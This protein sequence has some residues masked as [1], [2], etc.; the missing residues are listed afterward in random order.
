MKLICGAS[1][2]DMPTIRRLA[3]IYALAGVDCVDVAADVAVVAAARQG[4]A[5]AQSL[6]KRWARDES[7]NQT[8]TSATPGIWHYLGQDL[9]WLMVSLNDSEDP[10]F[11]KAHFDPNRCPPD[12]HRPCETLCP[13]QAI[14]FADASLEPSASPDLSGV[15]PNLCYGCGRCIAVCPVQNIVAQSHQA[16][17]EDFSAEALSLVDAVEIHTQ[18]GRQREFAALWRRLEP[19]RNHL[20]LVSISCPDDPHLEAYLQDLYAIMAPLDIPLIWQTDGRPMSGDLGKGT[21]HATIRL[22]QKVLATNLPGYVQLAGGTNGYT[23]SKL[24]ELGLVRPDSSTQMDYSDGPTTDP[25]PAIGHHP[26]RRIAGI[27][28][29]SYART[30]VMPILEKLEPTLPG[31]LELGK[32]EIASPS[33]VVRHLEDALDATDDLGRSQKSESLSTIDSTGDLKVAID[34]ARQLVGALK[35]GGEAKAPGDVRNP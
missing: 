28:Y 24:R 35:A 25:T 13:T 16:R 2:Q 6:V 31:L 8:N 19:W 1:Y 14:Q 4:L 12:C 9:P 29:G 34:Q 26:Q 3:M 20:K 10:H 5:D 7:L 21:T 23:A 30:L 32:V 11:R 22:A 18:A 17:P 15:I 27:A 33:G